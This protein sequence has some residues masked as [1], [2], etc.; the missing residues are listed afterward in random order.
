MK[1][2]PKYT[3]AEALAAYYDAMKLH[4][5][6]T[7]M[8]PLGFSEHSSDSEEARQKSLRHRKLVSAVALIR[9][10]L[11]AIVAEVDP[12]RGAAS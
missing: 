12:L 10:D 2:T 8:H 5:R 3:V 6:L 7:S 4:Q 11:R 9:D 1:T